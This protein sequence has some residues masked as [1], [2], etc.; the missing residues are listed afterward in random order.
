[1]QL[2]ML[3]YFVPQ[4]SPAYSIAK[5][6]KQALLVSIKTFQVKNKRWGIWFLFSWTQMMT[7]W[8]GNLIMSNR[9]P[10][11]TKTGNLS[12]SSQACR[13]QGNQ[14][15]FTE[16]P[17]SFLPKM[18]F[19]SPG[20]TDCKSEDYA[21][22]LVSSPTMTHSTDICLFFFFKLLIRFNTDTIAV[23]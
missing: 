9:H 13:T 14:H 17:Q 21:S 22:H 10:N 20:A 16:R 2:L 4:R 15:N 5:N 7:K 19:G 8:S 6:E 1:M 23:R 12:R 18:S 3:S 11:G